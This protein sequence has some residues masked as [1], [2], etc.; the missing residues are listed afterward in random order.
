MQI[1]RDSPHEE[2]LWANDR[3]RIGTFHSRPEDA[4]FATAGQVRAA[5]CLAFASR[6]VRIRW[7]K[8]RSLLADVDCVLL[9]N[10]GDEYRREAISRD[11]D[12]SVWFHFAPQA[13]DEALQ[14]NGFPVPADPR[15]P[16]DGLGWIPV[17]TESCTL[18]AALVRHLKADVAP[19]PI[20]VEEAALR[21]LDSTLGNAS[22]RRTDPLTAPTG[23]RDLA[24]AARETLS[25]RWE[26][27]LQLDDV[28]D[29]VD[30]SV[31]HLCRVFRRETGTTL[32]R[33]LRQ[34]RLR[35]SLERVAESDSDLAA[36]AFDHGFSSHSHFTAWFGETFGMTPSAFRQKT[37]SRAIRELFFQAHGDPDD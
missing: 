28:A 25:R 26:E 3:V 5:P 29:A 15:R 19:D 13:L 2:V 27:P 33:H 21:I 6:P 31:F 16:F 34:I 9:H 35:H 10:V 7:G 37:S 23:H 20:F 14:N 36:I 24:E 32:H 4:D 1:Y 17:D 8:T 30:V 22:R 12:R 18:R 11:G